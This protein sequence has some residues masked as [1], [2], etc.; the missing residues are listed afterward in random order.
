MQTEVGL[1]DRIALADLD[2]AEAIVADDA[3]PQ[4]V[5]E[6]DDKTAPAQS[7][8]R[9][10]DTADVI[11]VE[12]QPGLGEG[13]ASEIP[14]GGRVPV[15]ETGGFGQTRDVEQLVG[16]IGKTADEPGVEA[17]NQVAGRSRQR[18]VQ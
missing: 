11:G 12:R 9:G 15:P 3:A 2:A 14:F 13:E 17:V 18:A 6:I 4:S 5:V 10:Q 7:T 16:R 1:A 8:Q